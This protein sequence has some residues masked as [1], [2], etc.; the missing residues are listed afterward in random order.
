MNVSL[1]PKIHAFVRDRV[2]S[3]RFQ[4]ASEAVRAAFR[5]LEEDERRPR[6]EVERPSGG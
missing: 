3:G 6:P 4:N 2:T 5:L 1:T